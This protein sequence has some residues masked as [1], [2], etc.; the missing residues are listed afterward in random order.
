M[1]IAF[2]GSGNMGG[3]MIN[4]IVAGKAVEAEDIYIFDKAQAAADALGSRLGV[5]VCGSGREAAQAADAV[6]IAVKP[7]VVRGVIT[8][9]ADVL[10]S[11]AVVSIAAGVTVMEY[12]SV[13]GEN[14]KLVRSIP[15]LPA[16]VGAGISGLFFYNFTER[17]TELRS[18]VRELFEAFGKTVIVDKEKMIDEMIAVTSSSPAYFCIMVDAMADV[19]VKAGFTRKDA[20]MMSEQAMLGTAKYLIDKEKHPGVLKD[21][22]CSPGGT[23][24]E[25]VTALEREGF[26]NSVIKAMEACAEKAVRKEGYI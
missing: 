6:F 12:I 2:I 7:G 25:A 5:N 1:K 23:T 16:F 19:A 4:A 10:K 3:A 20:L 24:I 22:V 11:K 21:E 9:I 14:V 18:S 13:L 17:D 8:E 26:R 15:N